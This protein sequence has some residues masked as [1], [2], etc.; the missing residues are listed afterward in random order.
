MSLI[1][2]CPACQTMFK[3]SGEDLRVSD[4]WVRCGKCNGVFDASA[5]LQAIP[6][7]Q[8]ESVAAPTGWEPEA[9]LP[10]SAAPTAV[11]PSVPLPPKPASIQSATFPVA[12]RPSLFRAATTG[13]QMAYGASPNSAE[14]DVGAMEAD[15]PAANRVECSPATLR[16]EDRS[17]R[18]SFTDGPISF[19][20]KA[21]PARSL[22]R[23]VFWLLALTVLAAVLL[24][25]A[26]HE[27]QA[28][29]Q[30]NPALLPAM[31]GLCRL[32]A[33]EVQAPRLLNGVVIEDASM[34]ELSTSEYKITLVLKNAGPG[35]IEPPSLKV[36]LT[37]LQGEVL[38]SHIAS[39]SEFAVGVT[40]MVPDMPLSVAFNVSVAPA[41][42]AIPAPA[43]ASVPTSAPTAMP[44][45]QAASSAEAVQAPAAP[46]V[47][48]YRVIAFYP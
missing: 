19:S 6:A 10:Q 37:G 36:T 13:D 23:F 40:R 4:G 20:D 41:T 30:R 32:S 18:P 38:A 24:G 35:P 26:R 8:E 9:E 47:S 14:A 25:W 2:C 16:R 15:A 43:P 12:E 42:T 5:H 17:A 46:P 28:L 31:D 39:P 33:C 1:T 3:V 27:R 22:W 34:Q 44:A 7:V 11:M 48:G 29:V 21:A 45:E